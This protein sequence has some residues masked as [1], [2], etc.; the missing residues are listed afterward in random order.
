V[1]KEWQKSFDRLTIA[2]NNFFALFFEILTQ[3]IED[4]KPIDASEMELINK[5]GKYME[6]NKD[7]ED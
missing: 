5:F 3:K 2:M 7:D 1:N 6:E 4:G